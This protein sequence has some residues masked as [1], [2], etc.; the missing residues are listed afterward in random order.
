MYIQYTS[1]KAGSHDLKS[2]CYVDPAVIICIDIF[3]INVYTSDISLTIN[4]SHH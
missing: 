1:T 2:Q 3:A 4:H